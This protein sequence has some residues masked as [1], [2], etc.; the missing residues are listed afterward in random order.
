MCSCACLDRELLG[1]DRIRSGTRLCPCTLQ[2]TQLSDCETSF[3]RE[4][5]EFREQL[6]NGKVG[7]RFD[8]NCMCCY[9]RRGE[10]G[11]GSKSDTEGER[12]E[13]EL[14][15]MCLLGKACKRSES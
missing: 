1:C 8:L 12:D 5:I 9:A 4:P 13:C 2:L 15:A 6:Q 11:T 14:L 3:K 7:I 10:R